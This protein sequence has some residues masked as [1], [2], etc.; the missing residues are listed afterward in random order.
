M[1]QGDGNSSLCNAPNGLPT[2][3]PQEWASHYEGMTWEQITLDNKGEYGDGYQRY[4]FGL[5]KFR[6]GP[7]EKWRYVKL[8]N[9]IVLDMR[10][11]L[12]VGMSTTLGFKTG[13]AFGNLGEN[14]QFLT[15]RA[16]ARS[17]QDYLSNRVGESFLIY[18]E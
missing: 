15:D 18:L 4:V 17:K 1:Q 16:S 2:R 13:D 9:G 14:A 7:D 3:T 11:V 10:H 5:I 6:L 12:V 8:D